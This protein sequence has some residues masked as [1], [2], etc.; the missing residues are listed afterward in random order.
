VGITLEPCVGIFNVATPA[1]HRGRGF[2]C[3]VTARAVAEGASRGA[4]W[5]WLQSSPLG[6]SVYERLGFEV[7]E[8]WV[9]WL[10]APV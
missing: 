1:R 4:A 7:L 2:G 6:V 10:H 3:A 5:S 8:E 9:C